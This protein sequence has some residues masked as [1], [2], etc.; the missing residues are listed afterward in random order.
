[1]IYTQKRAERA[2]KVENYNQK[3]DA[4]RVKIAQAQSDILSYGARLTVATTVEDK[5]RELERLQVGSALNTLAAT[6][7]KVEAGRQVASAKAQLESSRREYDALVAERDGFVQQSRN[8]SS[9]QLTEQGRKLSESKEN[10]NKARLRRNLVELRADREAIVLTVAPVNVGSVLQS[11]DQFFTLVPVD[12]PL[13]VETVLDAR[14]AG[15]V[16]V[17]DQVVVKFETFPYFVYGTAEGLVRNISPDSFRKP[18]EDRDR[19]S[20]PRSEEAAGTFF[21]RARISL[22]QINLRNLPPGFRLSPGMPVTGDI[23][24][25]KRTMIQYLF[26]RVI[27]ATTEGMRE[28]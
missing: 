11:G 7:S 28:P 27:P 3:I 18:M 24:I 13:E 14:D 23:K 6:D 15:F 5:R 1:M 9:Q 19:V 25:G 17:G 12:S 16:K 2:F 22:D 21:Y 26:S 20:K 10:L 8:E 4:A